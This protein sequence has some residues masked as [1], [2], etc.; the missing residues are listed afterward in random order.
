MITSALPGPTSRISTLKTMKASAVQTS[1]S[2]TIEPSALAGG[3]AVGTVK[4]AGIASIT[5]AIARLPPIIARASMSG[6][7]TLSTIGPIA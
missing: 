4:A 6:S 1:P 3:T 7:L 2:T 5:A